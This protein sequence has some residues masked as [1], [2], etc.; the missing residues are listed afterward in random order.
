[1]FD[2]RTIA[3]SSLGDRSYL[4]HDGEVALVIDPQRDIDR[5]LALA[6]ELGVR[7]THV[8]E[9]HIH[10]DY[11]TGGLE[12]ARRLGATY[13]VDARDDVAFER[14]PAREG[15]EIAVGG[16]RLRPL[17]TPGHTHHHLSY[18]LADAQGRVEAV[19][20]GGSMLYG[21]TGRTDLVS[22]DDTVE[23]THAQYHSVRR[24][25]DE[26]PADATVFPTH[27]FGSFCSATPPS[28][29]ASTV[30]DQRTTN[31]ALTSDEQ[32]FVDTLIAGLG[33]YPAYYARMAPT[34]AAGPTP[35]DLSLPEPVSPDELRARLEKGLAAGQ[36]V[37]DLRERTAFAGGHLAGSLSFQLAQPFVTYLGWLLPDD[38]ELTL[39]GESEE[40]VAGARREL[41]RIGI[42]RLAGAATGPIS[43]LAGGADLASY[44]VSDFAGLA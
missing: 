32:D 3:T 37:V 39:I 5:V 12:L 34:N 25:V 8:A 20:T 38:A 29:D 24:L 18:A 9:T 35:V 41:V 33:A 26:L 28:G 7:I 22:P 43:D 10:T 2:V 40:Q 19:F 11:V 13:L 27:G 16:M 36:W 17:A 6:D 42:D 21:T 30:G 1:M 31:P 14:T 23:L 44:R 4:A 15:D